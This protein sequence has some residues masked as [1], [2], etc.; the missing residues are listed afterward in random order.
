MT[1]RTRYC[2][3]C[4][5]GERKE[6]ATSQVRYVNEDGRCVRAN[7]CASHVEVILSDYPDAKEM[8]LLPM[9]RAEAE[10]H[11]PNMPANLLEIAE[12]RRIGVPT[13]NRNDPLERAAGILSGKP[14]SWRKA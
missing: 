10:E 3:S 8:L 13:L 6:V 14:V 1:I 9:N 12:G 5:A 7:V 4:R 11:I 2:S